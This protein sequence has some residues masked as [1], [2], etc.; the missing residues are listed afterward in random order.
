MSSAPET[1]S[2]GDI[3]SPAQDKSLIDSL[4]ST[5]CLRDRILKSGS[6]ARGWR[7]EVG[8][9][10]R[11]AFIVPVE[12]LLSRTFQL[13]PAPSITNSDNHKRLEQV[14]RIFLA[15]FNAALVEDDY[16][17][18][19]E[20]VERIQ[21]EQ[22]FPAVEA[23][24][25]GA[26]V[27]DALMFGGSRFAACMATAGA[28]YPVLVHVGGGIGVAQVPWR[29]SAVLKQCDPVHR[30]LVFDGMGFLDTLFRTK[31][32]LRGWRRVRGGHPGQVYD[33]GV[34][35]GL[36]FVL[37]GSVDRFVAAV[38]AFEESRH[39][40]LWAGLGVPLTCTDTST[41][42]LSMV[43]DAAGPHFVHL[44]ASAAFAAGVHSQEG[45]AAP[46]MARAVAMLAG[47]D[48]EGAVQLI[49]QSRERLSAEPAEV[50][51]YEAWRRD[52]Q[53][54]VTRTLRAVAALRQGVFKHLSPVE[55]T[56]AAA[57]MKRLS[58]EKDQIIAREGDPGKHVFL[59]ADGTVRVRQAGNQEVATLTAG[60]SFGEG[61]LLLDV[62][63]NA[64]VVACEKVELLVLDEAQFKEM[65][66][67]EH[68]LQAARAISAAETL[69]P[70]CK[71]VNTSTVS[72]E[73][74]GLAKGSA[75]DI[76]A[77]ERAEE[78]HRISRS[79]PV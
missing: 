17:A 14:S 3:G 65:L 45:P 78:D 42:V 59:I 71:D 38:R 63:H 16:A 47:T 32:I 50:P 21:L 52:I 39:A 33:Q 66:A 11:S 44:A 26:V 31:R 28:K 19:L 8:R 77:S 62:P 6:Q 24:A 75:L 27:A 57:K 49:R 56:S 67:R 74:Q 69:A 53:R 54:A 36:W 20:A 64:T 55:L 46:H 35:R 61:A 4:D 5:K 25:A 7:Q 60:Q 2:Q 76:L 12:K 34:G 41:D 22:R 58:F 43:T 51:L 37:G 73:L 30:S 79:S 29:R 10:W 9:R 48:A 72:N 70:P 13:T 1:T 40:D 68:L 18:L 23:M 15:A